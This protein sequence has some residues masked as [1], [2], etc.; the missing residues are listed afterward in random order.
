[1][2]R[3]D[4]L[5]AGATVTLAMVLAACGSGQGPASSGAAPRSE[6]GDS[7]AATDASGSGGTL[8]I[9]MSAGNIPIPDQ[10]QTEGGEGRRFVGVNVYDGLLNWKADQGDA[11]PEPIPGL[12]E[13]FDRSSDGLTWTF[14]LR[15]GVKFHDGSAFTADAVVFAFD[16]IMNKDFEFYSEAQRSAGASAVAQIA[17]YKKVDDFTFQIVTKKPWAFLTYDLGGF[18]I[19]SPAAI[20]QWGNKDYPLHASGTGPFKVE[21]Y[22]DG[23]VMELVPNKEYWGTKAKLD[24]LV[25]FPIPEPATRLA[26]LQSGQVDWAE[27]PPPDSVEQLQAQGFNVLLKSYPHAIIYMANMY[28]APFNDVRVRQAIAYGIDREGM[29][30]LIRGVG[31]PATQYFYEGHPWRDKSFAGYTYN[32]AKAKELLTEAGVA[33]GLKISVAYPTGGSGNMFPGP[34]NEKFQQD[35]KAIGVDV[36]LVPLEWNNVITAYRAGFANPDYAKYDLLYFSPNT[37]TPLAAYQAYL[38]ERIPPAGCC[39]PT[40]FSNK[41]ADAIF[42]EAAKTTDTAKRDEL[43]TKFHGTFIRE[44]PSI[45]VVHDLNLRVLSPKV[46]GWVQPQSWW[47]DFR[48]V[49]MKG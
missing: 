37:Q 34:M 43:L 24:K 49:W 26:A 36:T 25:L 11:P 22:V 6:S 19:P 15:Q 39:N 38:T 35:M 3:L 31:Q 32:P 27:V 1:M 41:E 42:D 40:G 45:P 30:A 14:S 33:S 28:R 21:K 16:R 8:R 46:R 12:A 18:S 10:F 7:A 9:A 4:R 17:S 29:V 13:K 23:Q 2:F 20:K 5:I 47:G 44:A 48:S